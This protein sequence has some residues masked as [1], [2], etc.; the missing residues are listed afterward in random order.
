MKDR[1]S[2]AVQYFYA[3]LILLSTHFMSEAQNLPSSLAHLQQDLDRLSVRISS[4]APVLIGEAEKVQHLLWWINQ[5]QTLK[6]LPPYPTPPHYI[7]TSVGYD[8]YAHWLRL[9][10][11]MNSGLMQGA[12]IAREKMGGSHVFAVRRLV[13][14]PA[15]IYCWGDFHG[16]IHTLVASLAFLKNEEKIIGD[17][18]KIIKNNIYFVFNG[19]YVDRGWYGVEVQTV[20][21]ILKYANPS[22]VFL[23]RGNHEDIAIDRG[24]GFLNE[25]N[26]KFKDSPGFEKITEENDNNVVE[27]IDEFYGSLPVVLYMGA[28]QGAETNYLQFCHGGLEFYKPASLLSH[29]VDKVVSY[30]SINNIREDFWE[31][32]FKIDK[33]AQLVFKKA[34]SKNDPNLIKR[35]LGYMWSDF[36]QTNEPTE[37]A[38]GRGLKFGKTW[39]DIILEQAGDRNKIIAVFRAHQH[40]DSMKGLFVAENRNIYKLPYMDKH[41]IFTSVATPTMRL[42]GRGFMK[43]ELETDDPKT[44]T[45]TSIWSDCGGKTPPGCA[46]EWQ[47]SSAA[48]LAQWQSKQP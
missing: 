4:G 11:Q 13:K 7:T 27:A 43:I 23:M 17:D 1:Y 45:L 15:T 20:L 42:P 40:N 38:S 30:E 28:R 33:A 21:C 29:N 35:Q 46:E 19:D 32:D 16:D 14:I 41:F 22:N 8:S 12:G 34:Q 10:Q 36:Q 6:A 9:I 37:W 3:L 47:V 48:T 26:I 24:Y 25:L 18:F 39:S 2:K 44:W 5:V 31:K